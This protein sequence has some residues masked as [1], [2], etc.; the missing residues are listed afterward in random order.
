MFGTPRIDYLEK[1]VQA[2]D[3]LISKDVDRSVVVDSSGNLSFTN[4]GQIGI[5]PDIEQLKVDLAL[6]KQENK[7]LLALLN[8]VIDY[9]YKEPQK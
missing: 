4:K 5:L 6:L 1:K 7:K 8:E 9:V 3:N 2:L